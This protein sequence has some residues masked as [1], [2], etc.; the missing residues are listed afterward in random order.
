MGR[1]TKF[2]LLVGV[3][4]I[5]L[6]GLILSSRAG[7]VAQEHASLPIGESAGHQLFA[8]TDRRADVP[9]ALAVPPVAEVSSPAG[10][11][12]ESLPV[13]VSFV[14]EESTAVGPDDVGTVVFGPAVVVTP[15]GDAAAPLPETSR[16]APPRQPP[17]L[18]AAQERTVHKV[19]RG[20]T[21]TSI[22]RR[23]FGKEGEGMWKKIHEANRQ[24][25]R[26]PNRLVVGQELVIPGLPA[27]PAPRTGPMP[28]AAPD[29][30]IAAA[31]AAPLKEP[32][33]DEVA[34]V[35]PDDL[36][37]MLGGQ[38]D[39]VEQ[40]APAPSMYT[41]KPGENFYRIALAQYGDGR[42][43]RLLVLKNKHLVPDEKKLKAGQR[44]LLLDGVDTLPSDPVVAKR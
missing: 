18:V 1:E 8:A 9:L 27:A 43:A 34:A 7:L 16:D 26:D 5:V 4:F 30:A 39:L 35:T 41:V 28:D 33:R 31:P 42:M 17:P 3:V 36:A 10:P 6:F 25:I 14:P 37:R 40:K 29:T 24:A 44:I 20:D 2:G 38:G 11:A 22:A 21:L 12:E 23:Y 13:P 19:D 15:F 32:A